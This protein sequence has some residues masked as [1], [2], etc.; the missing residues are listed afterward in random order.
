MP[1]F[2][3]YRYNVVVFLRKAS[4]IQMHIQNILVM[5]QNRLIKPW[6][7]SVLHVLGLF[8]TAICFICFIKS[9]LCIYDQTIHGK[10]TYEWHTDDIL[11][12]TS[13]IR[14]TYEYIPVTYRCHTRTYTWHMD[15]IRVHTSDIRMTCGSKEK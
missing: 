12:H 1:V 14:M 15:Y 9:V 10:S 2:V 5:Y 4:H 3:C 13:D 7:K 6:I 11:V 8:D